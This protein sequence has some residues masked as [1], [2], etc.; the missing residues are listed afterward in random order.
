L[1]SLYR[2]NLYRIELRCLI[3]NL[4]E[5]D[6]DIVKANIVDLHK[7][8]AI[9]CVTTNGYIKSNGGAVM[10]RGNAL[11]MATAYP[12]LP[13]NLAAH[14]KKNGCHVGPI[15]KG[16]ISFP[17]KPIFG[18]YSQVLDKV[19]YMYKEKDLIPG[20]HCKSNLELIE[21]SMIELNDFIEKF[22]LKEVYLPIPGVNNGELKF[23][24]V[25]PILK[26]GSE[27]II[28]CSL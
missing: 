7:S 10:G 24:D 15:M 25:E 5:Q 28:Y 17:T 2:N 6:V 20:Y 9:V 12:Q 16:I 18:N 13:G 4:G 3:F 8:G 27:K 22:N 1:Q 19:R 14:I 23:E 26:K 21:R 11:A